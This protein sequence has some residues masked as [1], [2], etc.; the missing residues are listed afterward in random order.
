M[1]DAPNNQQSD[2][3]LVHSNCANCLLDG[4]WFSPEISTVDISCDGLDPN[5][6]ITFAFEVDCP[7]SLLTTCPEC[8]GEGTIVKEVPLIPDM[9][10]DQFDRESAYAV[11]NAANLE[12]DIDGKGSPSDDYVLGEEVDDCPFC[13][14]PEIEVNMTVSS[15]MIT[16]C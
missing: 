1:P 11:H 2:D 4:R 6:F 7:M 13:S 9:T 12:S 5:E 3:E 8:H 16:K 14:K 10:V 15:V